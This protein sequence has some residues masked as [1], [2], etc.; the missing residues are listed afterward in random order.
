M[1]VFSESKLRDSEVD[2]AYSWETVYT[3]TKTYVDSFFIELLFLIIYVNDT[4]IL[5]IDR[6]VPVSIIDWFW[7]FVYHKAINSTSIVFEWT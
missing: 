4:A 5:S 2:V 6:N 3:Q 1:T 7:S